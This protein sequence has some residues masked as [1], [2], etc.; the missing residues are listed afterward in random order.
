MGPGR[1]GQWN[2]NGINGPEAGVNSLVSPL[3]F[4][5][6]YDYSAGGGVGQFYW[7][8]V[9]SAGSPTDA[10]GTPPDPYGFGAVGVDPAG[11]PLYLNMGGQITNSPYDLNLA[12]M[13]SAGCPA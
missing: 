3:T 4:N 9:F 1:N 12:R 8:C 11:R 2:T 10:Y 5:K 6:W 7:N 13:R